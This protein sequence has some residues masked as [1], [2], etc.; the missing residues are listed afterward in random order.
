MFSM[1]ADIESSFKSFFVQLTSA[2]G[3]GGLMAVI[4]AVVFFF[5]LLFVLKTIFSYEMRLGRSLYKLNSWLFAHKKIDQSNIKEF[6]ELIKKA[7]K[8]IVYYWQQFILFR[9]HE[10]TYYLSLDNLI[11]KPLKTSSWENNIKNLNLVTIIW[12]G[13]SL[14]FSI[15]YQASSGASTLTSTA[16]AA[17]VAFPVFVIIIGI[18]ANMFMKGKKVTNLDDIYHNYHIFARFIQNA[19]VDLPSY[20]DFDLLFSSKEIA[21]G[22]PQLREYY[23]SRA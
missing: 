1:L 17:A 16:L 4:L 9:E 10:P 12:A 6:N 20:V 13:V 21:K 8:R 3:F 5:V 23:D 15:A 22:N 2:L 19:C 18:V 14:L 7:P 11:E